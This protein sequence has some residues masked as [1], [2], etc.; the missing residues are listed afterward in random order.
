MQTAAYTLAAAWAAERYRHTPSMERHQREALKNFFKIT[1][2]PED[3]PQE[4]E[5]PQ[6]PELPSQ[7]PELPHQ[8]PEQHQEPQQQPQRLLH[9]DPGVSRLL[10]YLSV[11]KKRDP[12][13]RC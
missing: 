13:T 8:D 10:G 2:L 11:Q 9:Q 3:P 12:K 5:L 6:D 7:D 1:D 4:A